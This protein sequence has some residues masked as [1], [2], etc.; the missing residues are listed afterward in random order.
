MDRFSHQKEVRNK[1]KEENVCVFHD[2]GSG[3]TVSALDIIVDEKAKGN[4]PALVVAPIRLIEDAWLSDAKDFHPDL[5][6]A[7]GYHKTR[8]KRLKLLME[9][10]EVTVINPETLKNHFELIQQ[11]K[12]KVMI[13]DESSDLKSN[14]SQN[15]RA[16]LALAGFKNRA[17]CGVSFDASYT[18]PV[19]HALTATPAPNSPYEYWAQIKL[20]TGPG[21]CVFSDNFYTFRA[22]YFSEIDLGNRRKMHKFR[23]GTFEEFC[24]RLAEVAHVCRK[25]D[26]LDLPPQTRRLHDIELE[27][28]ERRAYDRMKDD[29]VLRLKNETVLA[30]SALVEVMKL[31]QLT[32]GFVYGEDTTHSIG[33]SKVKYLSE[34][35]RDN[36]TDQ[37]IIW[38]NFRQEA[39]MLKHMPNSALLAGDIPMDTQMATIKDFKAG[40]LQYLLANQQSVSHGLT[41][42][43]CHRSSYF[44]LNYS[45]EL[46]KQSMDRI[47]RIGQKKECLYDFLMAKD[48]IDK[49]VYGANAAKEKMVNEFLAYL[50]GIQ[51]GATVDKTECQDLFSVTQSQILKRESLRHLRE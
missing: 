26:V 1:A 33:M 10:H 25:S 24:H 47:H 6:I 41:F 28:A 7:S 20:V 50:V 34:L 46:M 31:R 9:D 2:C 12:F 11:K 37:Q 14:T 16:T 5:D 17:K 22:K 51:N 27:G 42:V 15:T 35:M 19:R 8:A 39:E 45:Y 23:K 36:A 48:T 13:K 49:V 3:K 29:L 43:N 38:I 32:S 21:D 18:I 4:T 44:S 30:S 40:N